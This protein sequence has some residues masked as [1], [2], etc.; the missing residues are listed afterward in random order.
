IRYRCRCELNKNIYDFCYCLPSQPQTL[1]QPFNCTYATY[2][3]ELDLLSDHDAINLETDRIP[4]PM[5][6]TAMSTNHFEEGL[7]LEY[8]GFGLYAAF[9]IANIRKLWPHKKILVYNLGLSEQAVEELKRKCLV[10]VRDF[11]FPNY[12]SYVKNLKEYRWKPLII[13]ITVKEF[14]AIWWMD[15]S[16]R[17]KKDYQDLIN[18]EIRCRD[19]FVTRLLTR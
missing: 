3:E 13:A 4:D 5:Y 9:Q 19:N 8:Q 1:G 15:T 10:E 6:V 18:D 11:R 16:V 2:L 14:G 7:T 17:W 12:P